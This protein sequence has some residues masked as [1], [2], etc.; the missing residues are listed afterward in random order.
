MCAAKATHSGEIAANENLALADAVGRIRDD[1]KHGAICANAGIP[2]S[3]HAAI[4]VQSSDIRTRNAFAGQER[5][6]HKQPA[7][8]VADKSIRESENIIVCSRPTME[9]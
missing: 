7:S 3:I 4:A 6:S 8:A 1:G 9:Q 2:G 5:T